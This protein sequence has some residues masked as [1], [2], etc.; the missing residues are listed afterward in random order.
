MF[1]VLFCR[2]LLARMQNNVL[3]VTA[4]FLCAIKSHLNLNTV[5]IMELFGI[6]HMVFVLPS[7]L[8]L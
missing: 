7:F 3:F 8:N 1:T 6:A 5:W 4:N 2:T